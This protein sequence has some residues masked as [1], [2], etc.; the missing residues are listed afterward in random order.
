M[1]SLIT[2]ISDQILH[3]YLN[4]LNSYI[5]QL[6]VIN[7]NIDIKLISSE[8]MKSK[9][10]VMNNVKSS[11]YKNFIASILPLYSY[12]S[13]DVWFTNPAG[14]KRNQT[15]LKTGSTNLQERAVF[16]SLRGSLSFVFLAEW[17][18]SKQWK[19]KLKR[20]LQRRYELMLL[21]FILMLHLC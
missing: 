7:T 4:Q 18:T 20:R 3:N 16:L 11:V 13:P 1:H 8:K 21:W 9:A 2:Q 14:S 17:I 15:L 19:L 10:S 5:T 6:N 12:I